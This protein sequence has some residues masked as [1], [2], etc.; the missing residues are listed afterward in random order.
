MGNRIGSNECDDLPLPE[1]KA[2]TSD[3]WL[4]MLDI[5]AAALRIRRAQQVVEREGGTRHRQQTQDPASIGVH[6]RETLDS[7]KV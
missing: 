5:V 3:A 2:E 1:T 7:S 4:P 6:D